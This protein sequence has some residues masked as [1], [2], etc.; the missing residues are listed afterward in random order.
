MNNSE[1]P[2]KPPHHEGE[3]GSG[4]EAAPSPQKILEQ[5]N[6]VTK[7]LGGRRYLKVPEDF[8]GYEELR[9]KRVMMVDDV[10]GLLKEFMPHLIAATEGKATFIH[11]QDEVAAAV[12]EAIIDKN[13][14]V[15]LL[16]YE[17]SER[18]CG[19]DVAR[20]LKENGFT[21]MIIGFS[22]DRDFLNAFKEGGVSMCV[23]KK[24]YDPEG[25]L[26]KLADILKNREDDENE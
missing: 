20:S 25:T 7:E 11:Y 26:Q 2:Q 9:G 5:I 13:P 23:E 21:G 8:P 6:N 1:R 17:L 15:V 19:V 10:V 24:S 16:D 14:E 18:I 12:A 4:K 22:S 3:Q